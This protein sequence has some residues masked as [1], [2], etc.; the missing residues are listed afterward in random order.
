MITLVLFFQKSAAQDSVFQKPIN[1]QLGFSKKSNWVPSCL[2]LTGSSF[3]ISNDMKHLNSNVQKL[4]TPT[5]KAQRTSIDNYMQFAPGAL[6]LGMNT[7][8]IKGNHDLK[9]A[10]LLYALSNLTLNAIVVP[11]K[12]LTKEMRP[13]GSSNNS[14]PS[15]HTAEAFASAEFMRLEY[16]NRS[17]WYGVAGYLLAAGT[18]YLRMYNNRHWLGD[19][20]AG[21]G[22]GILSTRAAYFMYDILLRKRAVMRDNRF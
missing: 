7:I 6:T 20:L 10:C 14:F 12:H 2:I 21:A 16:K 3:L 4:V 5:N 13:D 18:G 22:I 17:P 8:G 1:H 19:I 11:T 15:G 9:G